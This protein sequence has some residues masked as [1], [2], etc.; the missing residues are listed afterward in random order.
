MTLSSFVVDEENKMF[1]MKKTK[2]G[3]EE[4]IF[5]SSEFLPFV[6]RCHFLLDFFS[7]DDIDDWL[8]NRSAIESVSIGACTN[9]KR[10]R[11]HRWCDFVFF[12]LVSC[13]EKKKRKW[14]DVFYLLAILSTQNEYQSI[15]KSF[16]N[17]SRDLFSGKLIFGK[18]FNNWRFSS[19]FSSASS[20][21]VVD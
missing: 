3:M 17:S 2:I 13:R 12:S 16:L 5:R 4:M 8:I 14:T 7:S 11:R 15:N 9:E 1:N 18:L 10:S 21:L 6:F 19:M 20:L